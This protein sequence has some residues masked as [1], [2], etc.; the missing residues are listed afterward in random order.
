MMQLKDKMV[1]LHNI[2]PLMKNLEV[3]GVGGND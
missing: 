3:M 1:I 2:D